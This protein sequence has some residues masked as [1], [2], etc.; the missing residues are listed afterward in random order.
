M[1][2]YIPIIRFFLTVFF[3]LEKRE[4]KESWSPEVGSVLL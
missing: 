2:G 3:F 4:G 1:I